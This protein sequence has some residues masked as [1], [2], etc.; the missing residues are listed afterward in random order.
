MTDN[1][2]AILMLEILGR[3]PEHI[4]K[5]LIEII[6]NLGK[7]KGV[8]IVNKN[9]AEPKEATGEK[10]IFTSFAEIEL[11][12]SIDRLMMIIF[13]YMPSHV[14]IIEPGDLKIKNSDLN[15]LF[16]ELARKLHQY[17]ELARAFLVEREILAKQIQEGKI[18]MVKEGEEKKKEGKNEKGKRRKKN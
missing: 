12:T 18:H 11:E 14:E 7:E 16:N 4:K 5:T 6:D 2:T 8:K 17:D 10:D 3:P 13:G 15:I 1:V 9:I